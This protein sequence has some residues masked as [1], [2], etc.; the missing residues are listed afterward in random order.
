[1]SDSGTTFVGWVA[2]GVG[3][4]LLY[5]AYK[6]TSPFGVLK[7]TLGSE[8]TAPKPIDSGVRA[9]DFGW[10]GLTT[11]IEAQPQSSVAFDWSGLTTNI[12]AVGTRP[13]QLKDHKVSP[14]WTPIPTQPTMLLDICAVSP[15]LQVQLSYGKPIFL[16]GAKRSAADA[17]AKFAEDP[18]RYAPGDKSLH[19][20]GLAVDVATDHVDVNDP[21]LLD[22]FTKQGWFR[23]GKPGELWHYSYGV[24]G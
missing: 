10:N 1:M 9:V 23:R 15:F 16:T 21:K 18:N 4:V 22:A 5:S 17:D 3:V 13:Q 8:S 2:G 19:V 11:N 20:V 12:G 14:I 7:H 24:P 6:N